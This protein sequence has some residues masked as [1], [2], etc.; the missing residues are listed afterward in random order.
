MISG[1]LPFTE[2]EKDNDKKKIQKW[3]SYDIPSLS[4][5]IANVPHSIENIIFRCCAS[6]DDDK[7]Y[8]YKDIDEII[9]DAKTW[10]DPLRAHEPLLKPLEKR[11]FQKKQCFS[12]EKQKTK[13]PWYMK[14]WFFGVVITL[15]MMVIVVSV[16]VIILHFLG[17]I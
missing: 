1:Q 8:R 16:T 11:T 7:K 4:N 13:E 2:T 6:M 15:S 10:D 17:L 3:L 12:I 5:Q 9:A 14:W